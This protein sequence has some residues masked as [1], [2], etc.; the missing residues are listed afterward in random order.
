MSTE[1]QTPPAWL[2]RFF[3]WL[4]RPA[5]IDDL[6]GDMEELY[7][8]HFAQM[9]RFRANLKYIGQCWVL[10]FSYTVKRRKVQAAFIQQQWSIQ[11]IKAM[12]FNYFK[13]VLRR[14]RTR[15]TFSLINVCGLGVSLAAC[16]IITLFV[17]FEYSYDRFHKDYDRIFRLT[18]TY[19]VGQEQVQTAE[20]RNHF[21]PHMQSSNPAVDDICRIRDQHEGLLVKNRESVL[22]ENRV[23]FAE[24]NFFEFFSFRLVEGNEK[25]ALSDPYTVAISESTAQKYFGYGQVLGKVLEV[26]LPQDGRQLSL[27][28][29]G[30]F[31]DMPVN[32][33]IHKDL[34]ISGMTG[35]AEAK[36]GRGIRAFVMQH[37]YFKLNKEMSIDLVNDQLPEIEARHAPSFY[38]KA[39]MHLGTQAMAD[40]HLRSNMEREF[41]ANGSE[42]YLDLLVV[43]ALFILVMAAFNYT[44]LATS[45]S[46]DRSKEVGVRKVMGSA[47]GQLVARFMIESLTISFTGLVLAAVLVSMALPYFA[48]FSGKMLSFDLKAHWPLVLGFMGLTVMVGLLSGLYPALYMSGFSPI[49]SLKG[50]L[51]RSATSTRVLRRV[52]VVGQFTISAAF[53]VGTGVVYRQVDFL[54][55]QDL[56][57][58]TE[59][60][61]SIDVSTEEAGQKLEELKQNLMTLSVVSQVSASARA[62]ISDFD[63]R[64]TNGIYLPGSLEEYSMNYLLV[65]REFIKLYGIELLVGQDYADFEGEPLSGIVLNRS[66][67]ES[68]GFNLDNVLGQLVEV[69]D[70]YH[71][72]VIGVTEDF[73]FESL[74]QSIGPVYFQWIQDNPDRFQTLSVR[75]SGNELAAGLQAVQKEYEQLMTTSPFEYHFLDDQ[76]KRAYE[77]ERYFLKSFG[78]FSVLAI[79]IACLGALG[80]TMQL[81]A[82]R[83]KEMGIRKVLGARV[84]S[85]LTLMS[86]ELIYMMLLANFIAW[87]VAFYVMD[88]WLAEF[89]YH[90]G[91]GIGV[92]LFTL[93]V[94]ALVSL[95]SIGGVSWRLAVSNPVKALR[96][97]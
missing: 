62:P 47:R 58:N 88:L 19:P 46:L 11:N 35:E 70:G 24:G 76:V 56:G 28:V 57:L 97:E 82:S 53:M 25:T 71:P 66:A 72:R 23:A 44:N 55:N 34:I 48:H 54:V 39:G 37:S 41:E 84:T 8:A 59:A 65:D 10:V 94:S 96:T 83:Q 17:S 18:K 79:V 29:T 89:P 93:A 61:I 26:S 9:S 64:T 91:L 16:F 86:R 43:L 38:K 95:V 20:L 3:A 80:L 40:I 63:L 30:V 13:M 51:T 92:F 42:Q 73:H 4:C 52:L 78:V 75:L 6:L 69:Y 87:P 14:F 60:V 27:K 12:Y 15:L 22:M 50:K 49:S 1:H 77:K 21:L 33:H 2:S 36:A 67:M 45:Q 5:D 68:L 85:I 74:H 90:H 7:G 31:E 32:S 81:A